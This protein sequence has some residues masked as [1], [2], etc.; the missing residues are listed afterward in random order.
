LRYRVHATDY[1]TH[2]QQDTEDKKYP[3]FIIHS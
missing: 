2:Y 3:S 1:S